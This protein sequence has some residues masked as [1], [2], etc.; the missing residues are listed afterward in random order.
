[1]SHAC[2][3][4][5]GSVFGSELPMGQSKMAERRVIRCPGST[6]RSPDMETREEFLTCGGL[7]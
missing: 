3:Q 4:W 1:M 6:R 5:L 7:L 2:G